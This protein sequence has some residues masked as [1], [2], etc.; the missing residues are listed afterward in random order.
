M[1][2]FRRLQAVATLLG[3]HLPGGTQGL[4]TSGCQV[5]IFFTEQH[6]HPPY[7]KV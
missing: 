2:D 7:Q 6:R 4:L 5:S 3:G 1:G